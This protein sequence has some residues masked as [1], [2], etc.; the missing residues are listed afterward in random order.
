MRSTIDNM[1]PLGDRWRT[2]M[3]RGLRSLEQGDHG[4]AHEHFSRAHRLAPDRAETCAALGREELRR[5]HIDQAE[6][7]LR[8]ACKADPELLSAIAALS[9]LLGLGRAK[10]GE[11]HA[12]LD[13][14]L[15]LH[16]DEP[17]LL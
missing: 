8:K 11:A 4:G 1:V 17:A 5:G 3:T 15:T 14:A 10:L 13:G 9:R 6:P 16:T 2:H 7:L 12:L